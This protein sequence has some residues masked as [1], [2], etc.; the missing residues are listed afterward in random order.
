M[1]ELGGGVLEQMFNGNVEPKVQEK[2][3]RTLKV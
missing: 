3:G 2:F 1:T